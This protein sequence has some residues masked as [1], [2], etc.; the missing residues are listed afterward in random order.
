ML[1]WLVRGQASVLFFVVMGL[2]ILGNVSFFL[3]C[4]QCRYYALVMLLTALIVYLYLNWKGSWSKLTA[5]MLA[6]L[7]LLA[8]HYMAFGALYAALAVDYFVFRA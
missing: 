8:S 6:S 1:Y 4:R 5:M 2:G 7:A 3:Y